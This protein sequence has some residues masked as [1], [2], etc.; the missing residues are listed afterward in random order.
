MTGFRNID[1]GQY[2]M[3]QEPFWSAVTITALRDHGSGESEHPEKKVMVVTFGSEVKV[4]GG[5]GSSNWIFPTQLNF[6]NVQNLTM[7]NLLEKG[8]RLRN[9][10][11]LKQLRNSH[12]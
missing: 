11:E 1:S 4:I 12:K 3:K 9:E 8:Q 6:K 5:G 2:N 10:Y 7:E